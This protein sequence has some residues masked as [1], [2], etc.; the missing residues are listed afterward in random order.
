[1]A[2]D[3]NFFYARAL[4]VVLGHT[5]LC[6]ANGVTLTVEQFFSV[7]P[8]PFQDL[9]LSQL[10][11]GVPESILYVLS[12]TLPAGAIHQGK[13]C[14]CQECYFLFLHEQQC[15]FFPLVLEFGGIGCDYSKIP[16]PFPPTPRTKATDG[17]KGLEP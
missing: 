17:T 4:S 3:L 15:Y 1:M 10:F 16:S 5:S 12:V 6:N 14:K 7:A 2:G 13:A 11:L 9:D 8:L